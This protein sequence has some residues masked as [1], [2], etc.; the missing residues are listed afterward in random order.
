MSDNVICQEQYASIFDAVHTRG[1]DYSARAATIIA[2]SAEHKRSTGTALL[3]VACGTGRLLEQLAPAFQTE[4]LDASPAMLARARDRLGATPLHLGG[5]IDFD[6]GRQFDVI[7]CTGSSLCYARGTDELDRIVATM[8]RHLNPGGIIIADHWLQ[9][10]QFAALEG[11]AIWR[12]DVDEQDRKISM[13]RRHERTDNTVVLE[14]HYMVGTSEKI[15]Y[16]SERHRLRMFTAPEKLAAFERS[17]LTS[18]FV[19]DPE[20]HFRGAWLYVAVK[21]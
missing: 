6:L 2:L 21:A 1:T 4:G 9:P 5:M 19:S 20:Q 3:D 17:G 16:F 11:Q 12:V 7:T 8:T 14:V 10:D 15:D 13:L 18:A